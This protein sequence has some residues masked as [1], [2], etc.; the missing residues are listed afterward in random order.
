MDLR[1]NLTKYAELLLRKG[2]N[3]QEGQDLVLRAPVDAKELVEEIVTIAYRDIKCGKIHIDWSHGK[4]TRISYEHASEEVLLDIPDYFLKKQRELLD[5]GAAMLSIMSSDPK[6]L[7]GINPNLIAKVGKHFAISLKPFSSELMS[8]KVR[9]GLGAI[10]CLPWAKTVFPELSDDDA[11]DKLW[12]YIFA[13]TRVDQED[14]IQA[15]EKHVDELKVKKTF[16]NDKKFTKLHYKGPGTDLTVEL[17]KG[18]IWVAGPKEATDGF[19]FIP[20]IPTEEVFTLNTRN[21]VNGTLSSTMPLN[22]RGSLIEDFSFVFKDGKIVDYDA[23]VGKEV[24]AK[25]LE[26]DEGI[27]HLGEVALVPVDSPISNLNTIFY[28]TLYDENASCHFALGKAYPYTLEGGVSMNDEQLIEA[29][30][31]VSLAHVDF[32][33]GS[34]DLTINGYDAEGNVT[35]I[36]I[37]GNWA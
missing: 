18:H 3:L 25:L 7:A 10:P 24:L 29:G 28:N 22:L 31:N 30:A 12:E 2:I 15:W 21:G 35:P 33:V 36:F 32:M 9:W 34:K 17:P 16:L 4:L 13:C 11:M 5:R 8:G 37:N 23:K 6:L 19:E 14:P 20:N 27:L 26:M 1:K